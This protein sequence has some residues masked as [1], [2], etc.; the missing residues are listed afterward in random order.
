MKTYENKVKELRKK[1]SGELPGYIEKIKKAFESKGQY[2]AVLGMSGGLD[3]VVSAYLLKAAEIPVTLYSYPYGN[4]MLNSSGMK[5]SLEI[6]Q[7]L[8]LELI[9]EPIDVEVNH[10]LRC[11]LNTQPV[12]VDKLIDDSELFSYAMRVATRLKRTLAIENLPAEIRAHKLSFQAAI[13]GRLLIG[14]GNRTERETGYFTKRGDGLC[15]LNLLGEFTKTE[16]RILAKLLGVPEE[17]IRKSPSADLQP[18]QTDEDDIGLTIEEMDSYLFGLPV[19]D[20][21][22]KIMTQRRLWAGHKLDSNNEVLKR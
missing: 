14:T 17:I 11:F 18:G 19:D 2:G 4:S 8:G 7:I 9:V 22:K 12:V 5:H 3:C 1:L 16:V 21:V 15:D 6:S 10:E 13:S 20:K